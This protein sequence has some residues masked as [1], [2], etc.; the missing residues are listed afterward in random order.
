MGFDLRQKNR[1]GT[2]GQS[3]V[4]NSYVNPGQY[5][6]YQSDDFHRR[7]RS[8]NARKYRNV[9][10]VA[11]TSFEVEKLYQPVEK[12][13]FTY[14]TRRDTNSTRLYYNATRQELANGASKIFG[15]PRN[16]NNLYK[17]IGKKVDDKRILYPGPPTLDRGFLYTDG[18]DKSPGRYKDR[19]LQR[20]KSVEPV[21]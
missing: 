4:D 14:S 9:N 20:A 17:S 10:N 8:V 21:P 7:S 19:P 11:N 12:Q 2:I 15:R 1:P 13:K 5:E 18:V 16:T 6:M 3:L